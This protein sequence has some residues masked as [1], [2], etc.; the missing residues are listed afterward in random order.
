MTHSLRTHLLAAAITGAL[1]FGA[2]SADAGRG[3]SAGRIKDAISSGSVDAII[4][5]IE[6]AERLTCPACVEPL[7]DLLDDERYVVRE[8]AAWWFARRPVIR[9]GLT[10]SAIAALGGTDT[11]AAR[12]AADMLGSF[13]HPQAVPALATAVAN[14]AL[15]AEAREIG[16]ASCRERVLQGV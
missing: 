2:G 4:A 9:A 11:T 10:T 6:R 3:G 16:R 13:R 8:V 1:A 7:M 14:R 12:N 5:E 15:G